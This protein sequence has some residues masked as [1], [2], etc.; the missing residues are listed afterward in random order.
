MGRGRI[1]IIVAFI[2]VLLGVVVAFVLL[3][4]ANRS[5][6]ISAQTTPG[7]RAPD[8][9]TNVTPSATPT[10]I[11]TTPIYIALF[12]LPRGTKITPDLV[13][14]VDYPEENAPF[15]FIDNPEDIIG[16]IASTDIY[17]EQPVLR[18]M[19]V[20]DL[21]DI[22][23]P[24]SEASAVLPQGTVAIALPMDRLTSV[25][26]AIQD[27]DRVDVVI[28][29]L[30]VTIDEEFQSQDPNEFLF[31]QVDEAGI[32]SIVGSAPGRVDTNE[33]GLGFVVPSEPQ[34]PRL[35]TQRTVQDAYVVHV[36]DFPRDGIFISKPPTPT[37]VPIEAEEDS[38]GRRA[39]TVPTP[40]PPRP[41]IITVAVSPQ[42]AVFLSWV[43]EARLPITF[44]LRSSQGSSS[45]L[46]EPVTLDYV[47][48]TF[49]IEV[50]AR[51]TY[52]IEPAIRSIRQLFVG[53]E[54]EL[55]P[56]ETTTTTT[57]SGN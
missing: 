50:P 36:G 33:I 25:A 5:T 28:S 52:G 1:L 19:L 10:E 46:T 17:R 15:N 9:N 2:V 41:D 11:R 45:A 53:D 54:I 43:V 24:R 20:D 32:V 30:F 7:T 38:A 44:L 22:G 37:P 16:K 48:D 57:T 42:D 55:R 14:L 3:P 27:G 4:G 12:D 40:V 21:F 18:T 47:L 6:N 31:F 26:Y 23:R 51:R 8:T 29:L 13:G 49:G 35:V 39:T 34:R 56:A